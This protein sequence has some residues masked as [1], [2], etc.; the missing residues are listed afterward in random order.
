MK[1]DGSGCITIQ[2]Q[3]SGYTGTMANCYRS[4]AGFCTADS[5]DSTCQ[6]I[7]NTTTCEAIK[8]GSFTFNDTICN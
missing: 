2:G 1:R 7:T 5:N 4:T 8:L 6:S 3:C